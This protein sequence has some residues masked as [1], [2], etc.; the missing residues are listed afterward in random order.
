[1]TRQQMTSLILRGMRGL[2]VCVCGNDL[3]LQDLEVFCQIS[4]TGNWILL[5]GADPGFLI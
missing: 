1:M 3:G 2:E 5:A 4:V